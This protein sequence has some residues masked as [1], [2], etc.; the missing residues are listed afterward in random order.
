MGVASTIVRVN[1]YWD[2]VTLMSLGR[3]S[4]GICRLDQMLGG[5]LLPG[6]MTVIV[7]ATGVGKTQLGLQFAHAGQSQENAAGIVL[8]LT[9]R[10]DSQNQSE[11]AER[12][13]GSAIEHGMIIC[14]C[15]AAVVDE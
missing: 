7:G 12:M 9:T 6:T 4:T 11:Y 2:G 1:F 14:I 15:F 3:L 10:G 5:G 8:D 13:F